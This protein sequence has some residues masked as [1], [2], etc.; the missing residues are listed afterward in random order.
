MFK[1][2]I[3]ISLY[4]IIFS[5]LFTFSLSENEIMDPYVIANDTIKINIY[6]SSLTDKQRSNYYYWIGFRNSF[7]YSESEGKL[8]K[9]IKYF[10]PQ[11]EGYYL[12][13]YKFGAPFFAVGCLIGLCLL[14][15]LVMRFLLK[16]CQGPKRGIDDSFAYS[17]WGL[18]IFGFLVGIIFFS[19]GMYHAGKQ[20]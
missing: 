7:Y 10:A 16:K 12:A 1:Q 9:L 14:I 6:Q 4:I 5:C 11:D 3:Y 20:K 17:T 19:M 18:I 8:A 13:L 15:Y 2:K